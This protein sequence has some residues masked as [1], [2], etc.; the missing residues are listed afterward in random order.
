[1][2]CVHRQPS[3]LVVGRKAFITQAPCCVKTGQGTS[4]CPASI[5]SRLVEVYGPDVMLTEIVRRWCQQFRDGR[6]SVLDDAKPHTAAA[7]VNHIATFGWE[8]L[9]YTPYSTNLAPSDF[10]FSPTLK[11]TAV[12]SVSPPMKTLR[13]PDGPRTPTFTNRDSSSL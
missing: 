2:F 11:R 3:S 4:A 13:Q 1:V 6:T 12:S 10:H 8:R 5:H 9:A 7:M